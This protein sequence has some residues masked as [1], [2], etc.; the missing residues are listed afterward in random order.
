LHPELPIINRSEYARLEIPKRDI[1]TFLQKATP[2]AFSSKT[3]VN[4]KNSDAKQILFIPSFV[5]SL[6]LLKYLHNSFKFKSKILTQIVQQ[7]IEQHQHK[8]IDFFSSQHGLG[9]I[10]EGIN[11]KIQVIKSMAYG[12]RNLNYFMLKI[13]QR[14]GVL[15]SMWRPAN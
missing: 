4:T 11:R 9:A 8:R 12:Y 2:A 10:S 7:K 3:V 5:L 6:L 13:M 15:G 1:L 14:C